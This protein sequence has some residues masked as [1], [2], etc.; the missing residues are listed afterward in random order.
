MTL[1]RYIE[2][3]RLTPSGFA[4]SLPVQP[5]TITRL[6]AGKR[7]PSFDLLTAIC[8]ATGGQVTPNDFLPDE[9]RQACGLIERPEVVE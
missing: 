7:S 8:V 4:R 5:S 6:L 1:D 2:A 9:V 3:H